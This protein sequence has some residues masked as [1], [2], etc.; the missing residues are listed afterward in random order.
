MQSAYYSSLSVEEKAQFLWMNKEM[1]APMV[2]ASTTPLRTLALKYNADVVYSEEI[3]DRSISNCDR[4]ENMTLGTIDYV[5]KAAGFSEKQLRKMRGGSSSSAELNL[6]VILRVAPQLE[7]DKFVLQIGTGEPVLALQAAKK[8]ERDV[9]AIDINMGCPKKFSTSGG[10]GSALLKDVH[11]A[12]DIIKHLRRNLSTV[13]ISA[14]IRLLEDTKSTIDFVKALE[15]AGV[16]AVCIHAREV[17]HESTTPASWNRLEPV[18][19]SL[20]VPTIVNGDMYTREDISTV[21]ELSGADSIMLARPA[22]YNTS[23]F[24][25]R[26][27]KRPMTSHE[28]TNVDAPAPDASTTPDTLLLNKSLVIQ[29]YLMEAIRWD[30]NP[31]NVKYVICEMMS[32]RRAPVNRVISLPQE[33]PNG[34]TIAAVCSCKSLESLG[35]LWD[36]RVSQ[37][38]DGITYN[39]TWIDMW[40]RGGR[41]K[42]TS[43]EQNYDDDYF[44]HPEKFHR[45]KQPRVDVGSDEMPL[46]RNE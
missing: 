8:V 46:G 19:S 7:C 3:V 42:G 31:Q 26:V 18:V 22:L 44:L 37:K 40:I 34:Q 9:S 36:V 1:L 5:R 32:N 27:R 23:I 16:N 35:K 13:P 6:P 21:K 45:Q 17:G 25:T 43:T 11:R 33:Y 28:E 4:V 14:K 12:C 24:R 38:L 10:M 30:S 15:F 29:D 39:N 20:T 2:R 41:R